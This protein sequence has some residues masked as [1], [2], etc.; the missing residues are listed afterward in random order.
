[1]NYGRAK[2]TADNLLFK[3]GMLITLSRYVSTGNWIKEYDPVEERDKWTNSVT[4]EVT[5]TAP[6]SSPTT[7][8]GYG[9]RTSFRVEEIDGTNIKR[10]D[11]RLVLSTELPEPQTGDT[12]TMDG[13]TF[14]YVSHES[15]APA[16]T[17]LVYIVQVRK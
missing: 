5:Y 12:F 7:Y 13:K 9:I 15:K 16:E 10:G 3:N 1:M 11:I 2:L 17:E 4:G 14:N 8:T 6:T